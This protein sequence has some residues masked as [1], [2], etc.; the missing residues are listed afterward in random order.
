M[1]SVRLDSSEKYGHRKTVDLQTHWCTE[2]RTVLD[3]ALDAKTLAAPL[4]P[5]PQSGRKHLSLRQHCSNVHVSVAAA[6]S[7]QHA[8]FQQKLLCCLVCRNCAAPWSRR[9]R[10]VGQAAFMQDMSNPCA[11]NTTYHRATLKEPPSPIQAYNTVLHT[12]HVR[13]VPCGSPQG[14]LRRTSCFGQKGFR[15]PSGRAAEQRSS[16][17]TSDVSGC[18]SLGARLSP[19]PLGKHWWFV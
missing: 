15:Q 18:I 19:A 6:L 12:S 3:V 4:W 9:H 13:A 11:V 17:G 5:A 2:E 1:V 10:D 16:R 14:S 8:P 7:L